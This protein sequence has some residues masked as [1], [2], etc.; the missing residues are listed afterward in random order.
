MAQSLDLEAARLRLEMERERLQAQIDDLERGDEA[1]TTTDPL[2]DSGGIP[3][4]L[5]DDADALSL[6][7]RNRGLI[8]NSQRI[9]RQVN[10]ALERLEKGTYGICE[11]CGRPIAPKR[12]EA[13][14]YVSLCIECQAAEEARGARE[15]GR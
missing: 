9:L 14:P 2:L 5:A 13:L 4:D 11:R 1:A 7:E 10:H 3:S 15:Q 12:L 8:A 6:A